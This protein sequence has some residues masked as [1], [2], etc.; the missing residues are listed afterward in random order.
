MSVRLDVTVDQPSA[1][2]DD[3]IFASLFDDWEGAV[4]LRWEQATRCGCFSIDS[5]QP[6]ARCPS[7]S[8]TGV[9][10]GP[11][12]SITALFRSQTRWESFRAE[13]EIDHGEASLTTPLS[14][15]PTYVDRRVRDRFTVMAA[16]DDIPRGRV[17]VPSAPPVPFV[18][19]GRQRAWRV[20][21][22][23]MSEANL[24]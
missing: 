7:C 22:Q 9:S 2:V 20:Q 12:T 1:D 19:A 8:G 4:P 10:Y 16:L 6:N 21:V 23:S 18:F 24:R 14:V 11:P 3:A 17:F 5:R 15:M 13:G